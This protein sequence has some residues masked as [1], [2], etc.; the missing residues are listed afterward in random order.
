MRTPCQNPRIAARAKGRRVA[1]E[2]PGILIF[3]FSLHPARGPMSPPQEPQSHSPPTESARN[4]HSCHSFSCVFQ[5]DCGR[6]SVTCVLQQAGRFDL[7]LGLWFVL[8]TEWKCP[9]L[10]W[11]APLSST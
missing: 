1:T 2:P 4:P 11:G 5:H 6:I 9:F 10:R 8:S 7:R 3:K